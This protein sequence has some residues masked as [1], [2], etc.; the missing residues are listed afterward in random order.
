MAQAQSLAGA[1]AKV[2]PA[3][4]QPKTQKRILI[5]GGAGFV[6]SNLVDALM[7]QGHIVYVMDNLFTGKRKNIEHWI[8][9]PNFAFYQHDVVHPFCACCAVQSPSL[10]V[11]P[12]PSHRPA[13]PSIVRRHRVRGDLPPGLPREPAQVRVQPDQDDQV[14]D[15][16]H[17]QHARPG[18]ARARAPALHEHER[19]LRRPGGAPAG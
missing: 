8:G 16:G 3:V 6:G 4:A 2:Y 15:A 1:A 14:L 7:M 19:D 11:M 17:A 10:V 13:P 9:H 5:T 18:Q 12:A